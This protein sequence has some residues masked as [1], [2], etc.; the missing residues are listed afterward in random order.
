MFVCSLC[1]KSYSRKDY[2]DRHIKAAHQSGFSVVEPENLENEERILSSF[3]PGLTN[4]KKMK[5]IQKCETEDEALSDINQM[6][7]VKL[8]AEDEE[9]DS[10]SLGETRG[11]NIK[12][13]LQVWSFSNIFV[14]FYK[15]NTR[16]IDLSVEQNNALSNA[17]ATQKDKYQIADN[18]SCFCPKFVRKKIRIFVRS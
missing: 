15:L 5:V 10:E 4:P 2:L 16:I 9:E 13:E 3:L 14:Y 7:E 11:Q 12:A 6:V 17:P 1:E 8:E 18:L